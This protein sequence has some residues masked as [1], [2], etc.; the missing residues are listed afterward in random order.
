ML[1]LKCD[2]D[3]K[4]MA[5]VEEGSSLMRN[6]G[7]AAVSSSFVRSGPFA[8]APFASKKGT[9]TPESA[10]RQRRLA[11]VIAQEIIPRLM[12]IHHEV[13]PPCASEPHAPS[14]HEIQEL[15]KLVL[16]PDVQTATNYILHMKRRGLPLD[17]LFVE[18]LEPAA[19]HLGKIW[20]DDRCDFLDVTLGVA[21]LQKIA[22]RFQRHAQDFCLW[23]YAPR[24]HGNDLG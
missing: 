4:V 22:G 1:S 6:V 5:G 9:A 16:G 24:C 13:L 19:R 21:R 23:R 7:R 8:K 14:Q 11:A 10:D 20:E 18:L 12:Q 3:G 15:V 17:V 2:L